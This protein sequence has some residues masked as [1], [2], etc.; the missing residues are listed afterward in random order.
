MG[1]TEH[2][3]WREAF[4]FRQ[5]DP[6]GLGVARQVDHAEHGL[7][8]VGSGEHQNL[9]VVRVDEPYVAAAQRLVTPGCGKHVPRPPE[10][11]VNAGVLYLDVRRLVMVLGIDDHRKL[12]LLRI[13]AGKAGV[14][15]AVPL[16]R[17]AH[18]VAV[19][20]VEIV[21]HAD[22]VTVV[23]HRRARQ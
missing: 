9:R 15:V 16:H 23:E 10:Q 20:K 12:Q 13:G 8:L 2:L 1:K 19:A 14:A 22:L 7:A 5:V 3:L 4:V 11:R 21:A 6:D 18:A 17:R